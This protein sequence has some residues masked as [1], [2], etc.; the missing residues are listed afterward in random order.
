VLLRDGSVTT[1]QITIQVNVVNP[2]ADTGWLLTALYGGA[3]LPDA[4]PTLFFYA[5]GRVSA[6]GG[7][8][9]FS[10]PYWVSGSS[11][12]IG[13]LAGTLLACVDDISRQEATYLNAIQSAVS[14]ESTLDTL[15]LRDGFGQEV[16]RFTRVG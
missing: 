13:P 5:D 15:I 6:F 16:A 7:C 2:L 1:Q 9:T 14:F 8:N 10:G 4:V 3:P 11:I 12:S